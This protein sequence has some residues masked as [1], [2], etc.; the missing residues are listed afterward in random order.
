MTYIDPITKMPEPRSNVAG[1]FDRINSQAAYSKKQIKSGPWSS[2]VFRFPEERNVSPATLAR[3]K[4]S[5]E[6]I[7]RLKANAAAYKFVARN[8]SAKLHRE[9]GE[10]FTFVNKRGAGGRFTKEKEKVSF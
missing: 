8:V 9:D 1:S 6:K 2:K 4:A 10:I 5:A 3:K 7:A